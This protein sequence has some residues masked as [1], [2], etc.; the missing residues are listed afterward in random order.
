VTGRSIVLSRVE[1]GGRATGKTFR[2]LLHALYRASQVS[3]AEVVIVTPTPNARDYTLRWLCSLVHELG[4][5]EL[6]P[7]GSPR[8]VLPNASVVWVKTEEGFNHDRELNRFTRAEV[9][10]DC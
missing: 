5:V 3:Y 2:A 7:Q 1:L 6:R 10:W 8:V 9:L 4:G